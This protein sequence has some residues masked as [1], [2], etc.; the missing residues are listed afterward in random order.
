M[1]H[2]VVAARRT[3]I[4]GRGGE[5]VADTGGDIDQSGVFVYYDAIDALHPSCARPV[6]PI[7]PDITTAEALA[8]T[9]AHEVGHTLQLGHDTGVGGSINYF[10]LMSVPAGCSHAQ[11]RIHGDGNSDPELGSTVEVFAP[12]FSQSAANLM[13]FDRIISVDTATF[14]Q[15]DGYEM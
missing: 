15:Q 7:L 6:D 9:F 3:D 2:V 11:M 1:I 13:D 12:R 10:N 4:D 14:D 5:I 8:A